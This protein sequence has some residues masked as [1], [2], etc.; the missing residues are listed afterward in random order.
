MEV[1]TMSGTTADDGDLKALPRR[2]RCSIGF[3]K[4]EH[5]HVG[6]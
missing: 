5:H 1:V 3:P 6:S 2:I 4:P